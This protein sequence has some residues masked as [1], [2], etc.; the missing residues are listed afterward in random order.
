MLIDTHSHIYD[1]AFRDDIDDVIKRAKQV[2]I[3]KIVLPNID[4][5]SLVDM[6]SL[7][8]R[9]P[10][11]LHPAIGLHPSDVNASWTEEL[12]WLKEHFNLYKYVAIG[13]IGLDYYWSKEFVEEQKDAFREQLRWAVKENLPVIIHS[14]KAFDDTIAII[15]EVQKESSVTI[16]G[17]FHAFSASVEQLKQCLK[18]EGFMIG[19]GGV[20]TFKNSKLKEVL[21]HIPLDRLVFETDAPYLSPE[22]YRGRRN[23][24]AYI[25]N[26]AVYVSSILSKEIEEIERIST[27]NAKKLFAI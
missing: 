15:S 8:L 7:S 22:P 4:R 17:V 13:E 14:R 26:T 12:K 23:E 3:E 25:K 9:Y 10:D 19:I 21:P 20:V 6:I 16:R 18:L 2:G 5:A 11:I 1:E 24:P 27:D